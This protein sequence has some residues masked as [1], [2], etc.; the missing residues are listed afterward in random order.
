MPEQ[1]SSRMFPRTISQLPASLFADVPTNVCPAI[2]HHRC[3]RSRSALP[4][5]QS[6]VLRALQPGSWHSFEFSFYSNSVALR[7]SSPVDQALNTFKTAFFCRSRLLSYSAGRRDRAFSILRFGWRT[8]IG[9]TR[10]PLSF[11]KIRFSDFIR[12]ALFG[13]RL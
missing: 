7:V 1:A 6:F 11:L 8:K 3:R 12:A 9:E 10:L 2:Q 5:T 13:F 4:V